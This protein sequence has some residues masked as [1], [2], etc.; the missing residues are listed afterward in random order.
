M[1]GRTGPLIIFYA[2]RGRDTKIQKLFYYEDD[3]LMTT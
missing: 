3:F 1:R 2:A